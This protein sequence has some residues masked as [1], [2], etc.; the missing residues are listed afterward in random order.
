MF[1]ASLSGL[2]ALA[3]ILGVILAVA[4]V[5]T[6]LWHPARP[7]RRP[8]A[9]TDIGIGTVR[10]VAEHI[11][12]EVEGVCGDR[13]IGR[14]HGPP[15]DDIR[16]ALHPGVLVMVAFDPASRERLTL[17]DDV[18]AVRAAHQRMLLRTGLLRG[19]RI[20]LIRS[21][22]QTCGLV[23][24]SRTTGEIRSRVPRDRA[25]PDREQARGR[26]VRRPADG[27]ASRRRG[28][29]GRPGQ[30]GGRLLPAGRRDGGSGVGAPA[31]T[32][33]ARRRRR[34]SPARPSAPG[35]RCSH[36]GATGAAARAASR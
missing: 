35:W 16:A 12:V 23:T 36:R 3:A 13:F 27:A 26:T 9:P 33:S 7:T 20:D 22:V 34:T 19:G 32:V 31:V 14:L 28:R 29:G 8:P 4:V 11:V 18:L 24:A 6:P 17:V 21:G 10:T 1:D 5:C 25:R 2:V 30:R 15:A